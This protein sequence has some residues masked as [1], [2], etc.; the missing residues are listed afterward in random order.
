MFILAPILILVVVGSL[1]G[2]LIA[3][4][5]KVL[6]VKID[7]R[8]EEICKMLPGYNCGGCG[9]S[10]CNGLAI[11]IVENGESPYCCNAMTKECAM[12]IIEK[13]NEEK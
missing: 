12:K 6:Y 10:G 5:S 3:I 2:V 8:I 11:D 13:L 7:T 4:L 9:K 1:F